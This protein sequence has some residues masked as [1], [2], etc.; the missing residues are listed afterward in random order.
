[1]DLF[2]TNVHHIHLALCKIKMSCEGQKDY[3]SDRDS[4]QLQCATLKHWERGLGMRLSTHLGVGNEIFVTG[5]LLVIQ[6]VSL[7]EQAMDDQF[8][9]LLP[10]RVHVPKLN[11]WYFV[12]RVLL[13]VVFLEVRVH[14]ETG[15][16][17]VVSP[18]DVRDDALTSLSDYV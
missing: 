10:Q 14:V 17:E 2:H 15:C 5:I 16:S 8:V 6:N 13:E 11:V 4:R 7:P 3:I 18:R 1:M 12:Q 9:F